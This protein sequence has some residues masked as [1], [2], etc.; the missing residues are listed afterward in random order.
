MQTSNKSKPKQ[1]QPVI[2]SKRTVEAGL[3]RI[4]ASTNV[5]ELMINAMIFDHAARLRSYEIVADLRKA[6]I[7][8]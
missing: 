6:K 1:T 4:I 8:E 7:N 5:N 2:G 3:E